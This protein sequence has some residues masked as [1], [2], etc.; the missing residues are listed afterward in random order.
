MAIFKGSG[1]NEMTDNA[2]RHQSF[3]TSPSILVTKPP[4]MIID[5]EESNSQYDN[6]G[7]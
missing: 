2:L 6:N 7:S 4:R 1:S 3:T 5:E